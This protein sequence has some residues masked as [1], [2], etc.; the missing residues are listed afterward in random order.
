MTESNA[1]TKLAE[2]LGAPLSRR[3]LAILEEMYTPEECSVLMELFAPATA[4]EVA[5]RLGKDE[6]QTHAMLEDLVKRGALTQGKTQY[7]FHTSLLAFHHDVVGDPAVEPV[8]EKVKQLWA[9]FFK[10]EWYE[11]FVQGYIKRQETTGKPVH[12]VWPAIGALALSPKIKAEE[13]LP[14]ED[15]RVTINNAKRRIIAPCGCRKLWADCDHPVDT[16]FACF[17]NP[18]GEYYLNKPGRALKEVS[19][20]ETYDLVSKCEEAGLVH[21]GVCFCCTHACE[22]LYSLN[23]TQRFDLLAPSRYR[24]VVENEACTGCQT[25]VDRCLFDAIEMVK[26]PG[27]KKMKAK[28]DPARCMGCGLCV[29]TCEDKAMTL[30]IARP[31]EYITAP[32]PKG[33]PDFRRISPWGFYDLQ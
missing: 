12:R 16:C 29:T 32:P 14:Q 18:R 30:E 20:Q 10:N 4:K 31:P 23:K 33:M 2:K 7:A 21:I 6:K 15:F 28:V 17:D 9:D 13:I 19:L 26:V 22:I 25:C 24:A 11:L 27:S 5:A 3:F 1:Y 8:S